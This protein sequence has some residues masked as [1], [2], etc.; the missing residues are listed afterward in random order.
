MHIFKAPGT[1]ISLKH[2]IAVSVKPISSLANFAGNAASK[3]FV[4]VNITCEIFEI[5][6]LLTFIISDKSSTVAS[7]IALSVFLAE[8]VAPRIPFVIPITCF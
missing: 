5:S 1:S 7:L 2:I 8:V 6:I 4:V 3:S